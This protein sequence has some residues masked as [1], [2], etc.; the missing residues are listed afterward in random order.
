[1]WG[2][3]L[4]NIRV[5]WHVVVRRFLVRRLLCDAAVYSTSV[6]EGLSLPQINVIYMFV[7]IVRVKGLGRTPPNPNPNST[8][9]IN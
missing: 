6:F 7:M 5:L 1:M 8:A 2:M 3:T 9:Y 4:V